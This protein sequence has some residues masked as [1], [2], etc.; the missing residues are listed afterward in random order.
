VSRWV[1]AL[2]SSHALPSGFAGFEQT[3]VAESQMPATWQ[4]SSAE[5]PT[6]LLPVQKPAWQASIRVHEFPSVQGV[7]S[8]FGGLEHRPVAGLHVPLS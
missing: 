1:Q 2:S 3:P 5:Q 6:L 8:A 4:P 7:P